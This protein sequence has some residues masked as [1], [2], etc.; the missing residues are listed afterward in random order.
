[1]SKF[2]VYKGEPGKAA[3]YVKSFADQDDAETRAREIASKNPGTKTW[4]YGAFSAHEN[5]TVSDE[6]FV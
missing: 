2:I 6:Y 5:R 1:M 3:S 4:V